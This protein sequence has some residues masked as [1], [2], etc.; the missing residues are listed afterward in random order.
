MAALKKIILCADDFG[1]SPGVCLG[2]LQLARMKRL[3][4]LSCMVNGPSFTTYAK[5]LLNLS[6]QVQ[7]GLHFNLTEGLL[8]SQ[9]DKNCFSLP[10]LLLKTH[11]R[12]LTR[13]LIEQEF[14]AQL[15]RFIRLMGKLPDFIDGHQHVHQ[16]PLI[17]K[18][19][20]SLYEQRLQPH[21]VW[22]RSTYPLISLP[23]YDWKGRVLAYTGGKAL[24]EMLKNQKIRH[25]DYFAGV[26]DFSPRVDYSD[27]FK[28]W[29]KIVPSN[30]LIMCHPG[31]GKEKNDPIAP[32][33]LRE[34]AYFSSELFLEDCVAYR[35][36]LS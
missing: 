2:L 22:I 29:L 34:M 24:K 1:F 11:L 23:A 6:D 30:T 15:E 25:N 33:R 13:P 35:I 28:Q 26:Y 7:I 20:M 32:A 21:S 12:A 36:A 5:E 17:R 14:L 3:S 18:V 9:T 8:L 31:T 10:E 4:A 27:L 19:L 16:F